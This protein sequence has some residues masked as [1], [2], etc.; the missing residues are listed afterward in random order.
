M[1]NDD[2]DWSMD[3]PIQSTKDEDEGEIPDSF[4]FEAEVEAELDSLIV[5]SPI[6][7]LLHI[8]E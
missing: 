1:S 4:E 2:E 8:R 6:A 5:A 7:S 3:T